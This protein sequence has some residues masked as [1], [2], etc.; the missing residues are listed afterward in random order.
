MEE[1]QPDEY[2]ICK[3][4][5][6]ECTS[7]IYGEVNP[8][9]FYNVLTEYETDN[10]TLLDIGSGS[11]RLLITLHSKC[12]KTHF[13]GVEIDY[14]RYKRS[15]HK[16][17][18]IGICES[19]NLHFEYLDFRNCYFGNY[20]II[21]C[22]NIIFE[23]EDNND[24]YTKLINEFSGICFLF[25]YNDKIKNYFHKKYEVNTSWQNNVILYSFIF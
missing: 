6:K 14:N 2:H 11:G 24:L 8:N 18:S 13:I 9:D 25:T 21:Y 16:S 10:K 23:H 4:L 5:N 7:Y 12:N 1:I 3:E 22:C 17:N 15:L 20:D 19:P